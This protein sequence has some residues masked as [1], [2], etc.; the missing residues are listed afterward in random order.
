MAQDYVILND[1]SENGL[2]A[3]NKSVFQSIVEISVDD[4]ENT[5]RVSETRFNRPLLVKIEKNKLFVET[6]I[7]VKYG[8]NVA[9]T[10]E[11]L[12]NKIYENIL[13]MTGFKASDV[14]VNVIGFDI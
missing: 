10:C 9:A 7:K 6:D 4:L 11:L 2:I 1:N 14:T 12:Q 5:V 3:I 13:F 8:A